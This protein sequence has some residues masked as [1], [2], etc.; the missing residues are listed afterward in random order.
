MQRIVIVGGGIAGIVT[1]TR[2]SRHLSHDK[3]AEILLIDKNPAHVWKPML[4]TFAAGTANYANENISFIY[5]AKRNGLRFWPGDL[6][7][8]DRS[9]KL[10]H[11]GPV[12]LPNGTD[13]LPGRAI[14]YDVLI[15]AVGSRAND[16]GTPGVSAHCHFMNDIGDAEKFSAILRSRIF[17]AVDARRDM[18]LLIVGG[19]ATG[20]ELAAELRLN[21]ENLTSYAP[22]DSAAQLQSMLRITLIEAGPRLLEAFPE[23]ISESVEKKLAQL[24]VEVRTR[25]KVVGAD[26]IGV[27]LEQGQ[28]LNAELVVWTAGNKGPDALSRLDQLEL[29]RT[30]QIA[31]RPTLQSKTDDMVF[32]LG[33]CASLLE[34]NKKPLPAT[35]Q[36]ARQQAVFLARSLA[37]H[38]KQGTSL[39]EFS[40]RDMGGLV[41]LGDYAVYGTLGS[42]GFLQDG[43]IKGRFAQL[44][45]AALYRMHQLDLNGPLRGGLSWLA[46]DLM[47]VARPRIG[48]G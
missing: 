5:H 14:P 6:C 23:R 19:G 8:L 39:Q 38:L 34:P 43:F 32:A 47:R 7:G 25:T 46:S 15:I 33:D 3:V 13:R 48:L 20:V 11:L 29:S 27:T 41:A 16:F 21:M 42:H 9:R 37:N 1:A 12:L 36:V 26:A 31:I 18:R 45:H 2:L 40:Y 44:V 30:G 24:N 17:Q 22:Q 4:H 28:H 35:A 10:V